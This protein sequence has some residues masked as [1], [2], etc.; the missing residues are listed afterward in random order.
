M[1]DA[2]SPKRFHQPASPQ[3]RPDAV[4]TCAIEAG[5]AQKSAEFRQH[6]GE[7]YLRTDIDE[8]ETEAEETVGAD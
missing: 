5:M 1:P 3:P 2:F 7:V 6:G 8:V 4:S